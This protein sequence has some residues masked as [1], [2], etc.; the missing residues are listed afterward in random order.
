MIARLKDTYSVSES[1]I[2]R[3]LGVSITTVNNWVHRRRVAPRRATM[4][5]IAE[6]FPKFTREELFAAVGRTTPGPLSPEAN[7][8]LQA[9]FEELTEEQRKLFEVQLKATVE[10]NRSSPS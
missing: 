2:A 10:Y 3:R 9:Y 8:R 7:E 6:E 1:E 4:E 5:K